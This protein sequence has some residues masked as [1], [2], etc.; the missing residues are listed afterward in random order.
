[1]AKARLP[2]DLPLVGRRI[3]IDALQ[4]ADLPLLDGFFRRS[5]DLYFYVPTPV[6]PRT[7]A[8]LRKNMADWNDC[9]RNFTFAIRSG[10]ELAG[11]I[12]LDDVDLINGNAEIGIA[13]TSPESRGKGLAGE[14][15]RLMLAYAFG[16]LRLERVTARIIDG[17][18]PSM[19]LFASIGFIHEG[20][21]RHF[22]RRSGAFL[23]MHVFGLL[24]SDWQSLG[25]RTAAGEPAGE[26]LGRPD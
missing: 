12:H 9:R 16:E 15:I 6:F 1:M 14:A 5:E 17:N 10:D 3:R 26:D 4:E 21:L 7:A 24:A 20:Q 25:A 23:D 2:Q 18:E 22:V 19:H 8:Q 13:I 11:L